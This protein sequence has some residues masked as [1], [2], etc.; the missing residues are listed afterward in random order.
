MISKRKSGDLHLHSIRPRLSDFVAFFTKSIT[1]GGTRRIGP[2]QA[3]ERQ[4]GNT[5]SPGVIACLPWI[6]ERH[7]VQQKTVLFCDL[8]LTS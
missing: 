4:V 2:L 1:V 3:G 7:L 6:E 5:D 8:G